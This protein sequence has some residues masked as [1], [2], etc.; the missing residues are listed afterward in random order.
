MGVHFAE[1]WHFSKKFRLFLEVE[2]LLEAQSWLK[3]LLY[4]LKSGGARG[5]PITPP[6][7]MALLIEGELGSP[8][9]HSG[10]G[11]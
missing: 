3:W 9:S 2:G 7:P 1:F 11:L 6:F 5:A 8:S 4:L 10:S